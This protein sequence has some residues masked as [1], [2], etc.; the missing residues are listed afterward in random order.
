MQNATTRRQP[1]SG[2]R[3]VPRIEITQ[4]G[5]REIVTVVSRDG[6]HRINSFPVDAHN[7]MITMAALCASAIRNLIDYTIEDRRPSQGRYDYAFDDYRVERHR[8]R[9]RYV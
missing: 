5:G 9:T 3:R 1:T 7:T 2:A 8:S 4:A 6:R